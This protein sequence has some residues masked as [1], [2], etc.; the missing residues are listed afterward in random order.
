VIFN[1]AE[2]QIDHLIATGLVA[3]YLTH[4]LERA[5]FVKL[6]GNPSGA[7]RGVLSCFDDDRRGV[8]G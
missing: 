1:G 8:S 5:Q 3:A 7:R 2:C 6:L 4:S